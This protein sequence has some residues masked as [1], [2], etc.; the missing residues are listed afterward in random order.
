MLTRGVFKTLLNINDKS[1]CENS[2]R[3]KIVNYFRQNAPS[4]MF[5]RVLNTPQLSLGCESEDT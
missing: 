2:F 1:F 5:Y 4:N 3:L